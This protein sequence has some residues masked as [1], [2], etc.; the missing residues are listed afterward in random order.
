MKFLFV[1]KTKERNKWTYLEVEVFTERRSFVLL[2]TEPKPHS[3][4]CAFEMQNKFSQWYLKL[5]G[6][7]RV[8]NWTCFS[9]VCL[10]IFSKY[11]NHYTL[12]NCALVTSE[13]WRNSIVVWCRHLSES[14]DATLMWYFMCA[15]I[16]QRSRLHQ[17]NLLSLHCFASGWSF[18]LRSF[19]IKF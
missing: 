4:S 19:Q 13:L 11:R 16:E 18:F 2:F 7:Q 3:F 14:G 8:C 10:K 15:V 6:F 5:C 1:F 17:M 9:T 12:F